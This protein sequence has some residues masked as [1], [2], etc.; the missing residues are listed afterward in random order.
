MLVLKRAKGP[1]R[2][3]SDTACS[4]PGMRV[5]GSEPADIDFDSFLDEPSARGTERRLRF[6]GGSL[7]VDVAVRAA[8]AALELAVE[9]APRVSGTIRLAHVMHRIPLA[10]NGS[11]TL[12]VEPGLTSLVI[13]ADG[14][15]TVPIQT[16]WLVL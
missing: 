7:T 14:D 9:T 8:G 1:P 16:A 3:V 10:S 6:V 5:A 4:A 13:E 2:A 11:T 15:Q 12:S